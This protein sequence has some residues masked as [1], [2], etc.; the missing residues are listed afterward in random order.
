M[1]RSFPPV[2]PGPSTGWPIAGTQTTSVEIMKESS[3]VIMYVRK[4]LSARTI[5]Y[6]LHSEPLPTGLHNPGQFPRCVSAPARAP[7]PHCVQHLTAG[8][9]VS[10]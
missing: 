10:A 9:L 2:L 6:D 7:S 5:Y 4:A 3:Q 1:C 8:R